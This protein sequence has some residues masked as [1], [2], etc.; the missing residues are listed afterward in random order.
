MM[1]PAFRASRSDGAMRQISRT[2]FPIVA[3][4][5]AIGTLEGDLLQ[6][7]SLHLAEHLMEPETIL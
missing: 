4:L 2:W 7:V 5:V 3:S 1:A 6:D